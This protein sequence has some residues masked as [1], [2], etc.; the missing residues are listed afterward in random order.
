MAILDSLGTQA[1]GMML[2]DTWGRQQDRYQDERQLAMQRKLQDLQLE[3][4]KQL[5][6]YGQQLSYDLWQKT[7][8]AAQRAQME[9]AGLNIG[10]MYQQGGPGGTTQHGTAGQVAGAQGAQ[11]G[12]NVGMGMQLGLQ[13]MM[14][15]AQI[16]NIKANTEKTKAEAVKTAGVDTDLAKGTIAQLKATEQRKQNRRKHLQRISKTN[17]TSNARRGSKN[18]KH[19]STNQTHKRRNQKDSR[20]HKPNRPANPPSKETKCKLLG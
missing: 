11:A 15:Q 17:P 1:L 4:N 5:A 2:G 8:Y 6:D 18:R 13:T 14:Q 3:G 20:N 7:N 9:K 12:Q 19:Q 16:E 10:L